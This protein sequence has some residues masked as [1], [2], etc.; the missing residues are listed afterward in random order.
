MI[1]YLHNHK[2]FPALLRIVDQ[3]LNIEPV[4]IKKEY[5]LEKTQKTNTMPFCN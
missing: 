1:D 5:S 4:L 2:D 3:E